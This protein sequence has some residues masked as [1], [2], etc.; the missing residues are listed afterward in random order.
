MLFSERWEQHTQESQNQQSRKRTHRIQTKCT[1]CTCRKCTCGTLFFFAYLQEMQAETNC[2][3]A[4][5][6]CP[7]QEGAV[8]WR[9][10]LRS[11]HVNK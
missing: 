7:D 4:D 8:G 3:G 10:G 1:F 9:W 6:V 5:R 2:S 11:S